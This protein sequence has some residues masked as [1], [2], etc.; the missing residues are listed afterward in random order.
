[1]SPQRLNISVDESDICHVGIDTGGTFTDFV[2]AFPQSGKLI[3]FK[4]PSVP[5]DPAAAVAHGLDRLATD[6]AVR[7]EFIARLI[8]GTTVATNAVL[9][10]DGAHSA[11]VATTG[12]RDVLEIQRSWRRRLFDLE[13]Q[14]PPPLVARRDRHEVLERISADG[15]TVTELTETEADRVAK[16]ALGGGCEAVAVCLLFSFLAPTHEQMLRAAIKRHAPAV[17]VSLSSEVCPE[18]RE[19]ERTSTT[20]MNAYVSA[21]IARLLDRLSEQLGHRQLLAPLGILQ[22]NGGV[23]SAN[24]ARGFPVNTLL[25]GPAGGVVGAS[26]AAA[27]A[28]LDNVITMD[29]GGTSL[30]VCLVQGGELT[31]A[32]DGEVGGYPVK[33]PQVNVHTIGAGGG[34]IA[35]VESGVLKVGPRSAGAIPGPACYGRGGLLPTSTDAAVVLGYIVAERFAEGQIQLDKTAARSVIDTHIASPLGMDLLAAAL[36]M[37]RVQVA[38][39]V[40]GVR[41]VS[42]EKGLDPREFTLLPFGGAGGLYAGLVAEELGMSR[43]MVP[44]RPGV[45]SANGMLLTN[46]KHTAVTTRLIA[47]EE[48]TAAALQAQFTTL[49]EPLLEQMHREGYGP[50]DVAIEHSCDMRYRGQAYEVNVTLPSPLCD[51]IAASHLFHQAHAVRYGR[52]APKEPVEMVNF[53][54]IVSATLPSIQTRTNDPSEDTSPPASLHQNCYFGDRLGALSCP[55]FERDRLGANVSLQGPA[56]VTESGAVTV[57]FPDHIAHT[58]HFGNLLITVPLKRDTRSAQH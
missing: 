52:S 46:L 13:L 31:L 57:L 53:R 14:S 26:K 36:A 20:A 1:M 38:D 48:M 2:V 16:Q 27:L 22:S 17:H 54:V 3:D 11:L 35:R 33:V 41:A 9:E 43:V 6:Y 45:L 5:S 32:S 19:Y 25:S 37:V 23:M 47:S 39:M 15:S 12:T 58:D 50:E 28:G 10:H 30:D 49:A 29:M 7:P 18:F 8:F 21:K 55:V 4:V 24:H 42:V 40:A 34:S 44:V 51:G 56:L